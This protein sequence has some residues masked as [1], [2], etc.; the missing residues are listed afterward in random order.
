MMGSKNVAIPGHI[1][2]GP[3]NTLRQ[4]INSSN[5]SFEKIHELGVAL[6]RYCG[7]KI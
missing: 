5:H 2:S 4:A 7:V 3:Y 6:L 1:V